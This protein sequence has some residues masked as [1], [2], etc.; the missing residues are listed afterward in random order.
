MFLLGDAFLRNFYSVYDF[1]NQAVK[2]AINIHSKNIVGIKVLPSRFIIF[3]IYC[4][5]MFLT[6]CISILIYKICKARYI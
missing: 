1:D 2:L 6:L 3:L 5:I 4:A